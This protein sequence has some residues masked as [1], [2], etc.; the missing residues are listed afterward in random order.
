MFAAWMSHCAE[1]RM[2]IG[3]APVDKEQAG[4]EASCSEGLATQQQPLL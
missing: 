4:H 3:P 2:A 1:L